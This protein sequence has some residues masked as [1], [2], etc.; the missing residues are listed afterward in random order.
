MWLDA[1]N[2]GPHLV[3]RVVQS[4]MHHLHGVGADSVP[5][6]LHA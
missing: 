6:H 2:I 1:A 3:V 4:T 5:S